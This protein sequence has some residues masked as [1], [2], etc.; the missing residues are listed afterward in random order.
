LLRNRR[1]VSNIDEMGPTTTFKVSEISWV[2]LSWERWHILLIVICII[3]YSNVL[4]I[5]LQISTA[6]D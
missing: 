5:V 4:F 2:S 6:S 3:V 1:C